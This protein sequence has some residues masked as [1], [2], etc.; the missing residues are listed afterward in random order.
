[1]TIKYDN[2]NQ[3]PNGTGIGTVVARTVNDVVT[4]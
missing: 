4:G 3:T 2:A 1:M